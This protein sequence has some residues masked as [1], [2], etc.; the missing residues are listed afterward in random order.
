MSDLHHVID[1]DFCIGCGVC[2]VIA[3]NSI[4]IA[5][6]DFG[7][8][9]AS[10]A[11]FASLDEDQ[12]H[13]ASLVCPFSG[14]HPDEDD[15]ARDLYP[16]LPFHSEIGRFSKTYAGWV[17]LG[18]FRKSG[19]SGGL[20]TWVCCRLL[21]DGLVDAVVH[22]K[23]V[24][25]VKHSGR[26][27]QYGISSSVEEIS[28]C[29]GSR[30]YPVELSGVLEQLEENK[31]KRVAFV[32]L[33]CFIKAVRLLALNDSLFAAKVTFCVSL[34][35]G[36]LKS[37]AFQELL[38]WQVGI[39]P[40]DTAQF[41]FRKK[42][43]GRPASHYGICATSLQANHKVISPMSE[44]YGGDWGQGLFKYNA[45]DYCDDV[46]GETADISIGDAWLPEYVDDYR[47]T[48]VVVVR[49]PVLQALLEKGNLDKI[50]HLE[51]IHV[52]KVAESQRAGLSHR[53]EG[54]KYR[55]A[56]KQA[57][58]EWYPPKRVQPSFQIPSKRKAIYDQ[59]V[60]LQYRSHHAFARA[61]EKAD[62]S[63][64]FSEMKPLVDTY[65][66]LYKMPTYL[67]IINKLR[68]CAMRLTSRLWEIT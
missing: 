39:K 62:L 20:T 31:F 63:L 23:P 42:L 18:D 27:F 24:S 64:F 51:S 59:R 2:K 5:M 53:R 28:S 10:I 34:F 19:S 50:I 15:L 3:D 60:L 49:H 58:G 66:S 33:P 46:V 54:L 7:K 37:A 29:S 57:K 22:V 65:R 12:L 25:P 61:K 44:L 41:N 36:H 21:E 13:R 40:G 38:S 67:K 55:L 14:S 68:L 1:G 16:G 35:C 48:N 4:S 45:C 26:L 47:G 56:V 6:D 32:G 8:Y 11:G 43:I 9:R 52:D 30:Y 17:E